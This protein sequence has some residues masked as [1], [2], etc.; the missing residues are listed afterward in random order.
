MKEISEEMKM[1]I[2]DLLEGNLKEDEKQL[3]LKQIEAS[4]DL[5]REYQLMSQ[6][7]FTPE[8]ETVFADKHALYHKAGMFVI[9]SPM[10]RNIAAAVALLACSFSVWYFGFRSAQSSHLSTEA[11]IQASIQDNDT[12]LK[13]I[14]APL[15]P[16][17][18]KPVE[19]KFAP[20]QAIVTQPV[21]KPKTEHA[22][23]PVDF[24][25]EV[26]YPEAYIAYA[27]EPELASIQDSISEDPIVVNKIPVSSSKKRSLSYKL[28]NG[29]RA[30]L[31]NL[32][33]PEVHFTTE[34]RTNKAIPAV[35]M[36]IKTYKTDVIATLI[37]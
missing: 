36:E 33:L 32:Q 11:S 16:L 17:G 3:L 13:N 25:P 20:K 29:S 7:Y 35:K 21:I 19:Q 12:A 27:H 15:A 2:F 5:K 24:E 28:L 34:K 1:Q 4:A 30:M 10:R 6:T 9:W 23:K 18:P 26:T 37:D 14:A 22:E 8:K 31:A